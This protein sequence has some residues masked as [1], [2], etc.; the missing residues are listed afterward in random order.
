VVTSTKA[1]RQVTAPAADVAV[2]T[3]ASTDGLV[4]ALS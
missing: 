2:R 4:T 3:F 1:R